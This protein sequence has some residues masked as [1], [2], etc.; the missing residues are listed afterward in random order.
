MFG[1]N[2]SSSSP[3]LSSLDHA[4]H[5]VEQAAQAV[6]ATQQLAQEALNGLSDGVQ[7]LR[8][9]AEPML[10]RAADRASH[11]AHQT[12]DAVRDQSLRLREQALRAGT[13]STNYIRAEP[14]KS[15]LMAAAAGAALMALVN[16]L[17]RTRS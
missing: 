15:V 17:N 12:V 1:S 9:Q 2:K 6:Q 10:H 3:A 7:E 11:L 4:G 5:P 16:M 14:L 13:N 8:D